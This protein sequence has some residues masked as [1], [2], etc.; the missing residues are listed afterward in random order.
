MCP[1]GGGTCRSCP[2]VLG[3]V[4][5]P[6]WWGVSGGPWSVCTTSGL[7]YILCSS[8][9]MIVVILSPP[10]FYSPCISY[11]PVTRTE[12]V[13]FPSGYLV[14][15]QS[16][17]ASGTP[18]DLPPFR[19]PMKPTSPSTVLCALLY[20]TPFGGHRGSHLPRALGHS[21]GQKWARRTSPYSTCDFPIL[22]LTEFHQDHPVFH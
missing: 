15:P 18:S 12:N 16:V 9:L 3:C 19:L 11:P 1:L 5:A 8:V 7:W 14:G 22:C 6:S 4:P 21:L 13:V 2:S 20:W 17:S 10:V